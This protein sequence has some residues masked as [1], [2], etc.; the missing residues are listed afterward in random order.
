MEQNANLLRVLGA[1][2]LTVTEVIYKQGN[3]RLERTLTYWI[4]IEDQ[5]A[6]MIF[7]FIYREIYI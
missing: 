6:L 5:Y 2:F 7:K 4:V 1:R 3:D